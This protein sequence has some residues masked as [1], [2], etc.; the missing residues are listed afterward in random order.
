ML[1]R[2]VYPLLEEYFGGNQKQISEVLE[3]AGARVKIAD[4]L[5]TIPVTLDRVDNQAE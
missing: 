1:R 3:A 5:I 4:G 2:K